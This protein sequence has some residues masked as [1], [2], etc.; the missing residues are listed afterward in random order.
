MAKSDGSITTGTVSP[1][2]WEKFR[3]SSEALPSPNLYAVKI[4][5]IVDGF[6]YFVRVAAINAVSS[7]S[8]LRLSFYLFHL[9]KQNPF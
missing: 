2:A 1:A 9:G 3:N 8:Y 6:V 7:S 5:D 4:D